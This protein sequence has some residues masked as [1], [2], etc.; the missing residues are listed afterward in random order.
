M[1]CLVEWENC[2][3]PCT[4]AMT[5]PDWHKEKA[6]QVTLLRNGSRISI[7]QALRAKTAEP[8]IAQIDT[9]SSLEH[10]ALLA[11]FELDANSN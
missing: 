2:A 10:V 1:P 5:P 9:S 6:R 8:T 11:L 4:E 3:A 7:A